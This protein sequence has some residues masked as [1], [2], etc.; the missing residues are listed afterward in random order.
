LQIAWFLFYSLQ[1]RMSNIESIPLTS[2]QPLFINCIFEQLEST[3]LDLDIT[4]T[5][6]DVD[7]YG[8]PKELAETMDQGLNEVKTA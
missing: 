3:S 7:S 2:F 5:S 8:H 6:K 1:E 4:P